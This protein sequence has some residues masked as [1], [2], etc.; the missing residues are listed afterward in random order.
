MTVTFWNSVSALYKLTSRFICRWQ[1]QEFL[2]AATPA[3]TICTRRFCCGEKITLYLGNNFRFE[4]MLWEVINVLG[5]WI[6]WKA[7][8][9]YF[10]WFNI[11]ICRFCFLIFFLFAP[12]WVHSTNIRKTRNFFDI[13][14]SESLLLD[15]L[16]SV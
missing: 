2:R 9:K 16:K 6:L 1:Y 10:N 12:F 4:L 8:I 7:N 14:R 5:Q 11:A 13:C 15:I 3:S